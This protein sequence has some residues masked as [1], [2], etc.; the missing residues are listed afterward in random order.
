MLKVLGHHISHNK[1]APTR[2]RPSISLPFRRHV[3]R[4]YL[5]L[6]YDVNNIQTWLPSLLFEY[7]QILFHH[8]SRHMQNSFPG[9][10]SDNLLPPSGGGCSFP[11]CPNRQADGKRCDNCAHLA[12]NG[13]KE[14]THLLKLVCL[15]QRANPPPPVVFHAPSI[16]SSRE[17]SLETTH[18]LKSQLN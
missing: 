8:P 1:T 2:P 18:I 5:T 16:Q 4:L 7:L 14:I 17:I 6:F 15:L 3:G 10:G 9:R 13:R 12:S 11:P